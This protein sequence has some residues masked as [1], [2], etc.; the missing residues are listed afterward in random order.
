MGTGTGT[1]EPTL[2]RPPSSGWLSQLGPRMQRAYTR[3]SANGRPDGSDGT[4]Q[5]GGGCLVGVD[6]TSLIAPGCLL[7]ESVS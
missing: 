7:T 4:W 5:G 2:P 6:G 1:G 3:D